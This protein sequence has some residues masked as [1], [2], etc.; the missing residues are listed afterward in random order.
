MSGASEGKIRAGVVGAG[1]MGQYHILALMELWEVELA[2][3]VD[4]D[5]T[6]ARELAGTYGTRAFAVLQSLHDG[7]VLPVRVV[8]HR[9]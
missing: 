7:V 2:G 4:A 9:Q 1:H 3:I 8:Q 6:R 5:I